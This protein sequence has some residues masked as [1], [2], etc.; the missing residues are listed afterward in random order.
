MIQKIRVPNLHIINVTI[1][2]NNHI[3]TKPI[4]ASLVPNLQWNIS[5]YPF[6]HNLR[7]SQKNHTSYFDTPTTMK[8]Y[9][10]PII[11]LNN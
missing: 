4:H 3:S 6:N 7:K 8:S 9:R 2:K 5:L 1:Y 11:Q 10:N